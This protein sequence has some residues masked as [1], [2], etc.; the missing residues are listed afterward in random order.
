MGL[1]LGAAAQAQPQ[2][3]Q[4]TTHGTPKE[5]APAAQS[6]NWPGFLGPRR[7]GI[8][9]ET[10]LLDAW[11]EAR[12]SL[13]WELNCGSG[14]SG[15]A[16]A[17]GRLVLPHRVG[18]QEIIDCVDAST[19]AA[20]WRASFPCDYK[21]EFINDHGPRSTALIDGERVYVHGVL[22]V[23]RCFELATGKLLWHADW[24]Q[25][26]NLPD[27]WLG[28]ISSP[29]V[30]GD[31]L[32]QNLGDPKGG[33]AAAFNK[34]TGELVWR[35][36]PTNPE[37]APWGA[38]CAS[39]VIAEVA[40]RDRLFVLTGGKSQPPRGGLMVLDPKTGALEFSYHFRSRTYYSVNG[41]SPL[42]MGDLVFLSASYGVGSV[43]L[44]LGIESKPDGEPYAMLWKDRRLGLQ[45]GN[46]LFR[47][48]K[49]YV[50]NGSPGGA[51]SLRVIDPGNGKQLAELDLTH[52][53][54]VGAGAEAEEVESSS[55]EASLLLADG[56]LF[57]LGDTGTLFMLDVS[58]VQ[59][60]LMASAALFHARWAWTPPVISG[61]LLYVHQSTEDG[62]TG[63]TARLL[64][65]DLRA[66][67]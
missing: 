4:L 10:H 9:E 5:L 62:H 1:A 61:G 31:L 2:S 53:G 19:G 22:G 52:T 23:M 60:K 17:G 65:Y 16:I 50:A 58:A 3:K 39:P 26:Y 33:S 66:A 38:S 57:C 55:G 36:S 37:H 42:I 14:F 29:L 56:K 34:L 64:C 21:D 47:D 24:A 32:I 40:G 7:D 44:D 54:R 28:Q 30:Y 27:A 48:G 6:E 8:S 35:T 11:G 15:P 43:C 25:K 12:P 18:D 67:E 49:L 51:G 20:L 46:A 59:P 63:K 13:L 45:F 41:S